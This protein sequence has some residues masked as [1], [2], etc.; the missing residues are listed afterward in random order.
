MEISRRI[1]VGSV[2][3][4]SIDFMELKPPVLIFFG[5]SAWTILPGIYCAED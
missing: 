2:S 5:Y 4:L 3:A 1:Q